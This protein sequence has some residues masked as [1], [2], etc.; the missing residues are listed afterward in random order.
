MA[1]LH[2][3]GVGEAAVVGGVGDAVA[4]AAESVGRRAT[5]A[6]VRRFDPPEDGARSDALGREDAR[7]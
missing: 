6:G 5:G 1:L 4:S 2:V 3:H 7:S